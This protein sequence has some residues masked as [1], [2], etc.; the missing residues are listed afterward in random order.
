M[1]PRKDG[2][3]G[4]IVNGKRDGKPRKNYWLR[5]MDI[6]NIERLK[7]YWYVVHDNDSFQDS[8]EAIEKELIDIYKPR[9]NR[10]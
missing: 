8:P 3:K 4:R 7:F 10:T 6:E 5:E 1:I 2:I 9:W